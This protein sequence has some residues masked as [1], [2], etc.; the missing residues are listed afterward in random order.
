MA[1][2][3]Q[4]DLRSSACESFVGHSQW[5]YREWCSCHTAIQAATTGAKDIGL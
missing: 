5:H 4:G 3:K 2:E 1:L